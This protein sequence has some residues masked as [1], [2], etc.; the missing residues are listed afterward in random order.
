MIIGQ[1]RAGEDIAVALEV[2]DGDVAGL[3]VTASMLLI[4]SVQGA[5]IAM[6][7][8]PRAAT[9]TIPAG[10]NIVLPAAQSANIRAGR[11]I[12]DAKFQGAGS[13]DI[14]KQSANIMVSKSGFG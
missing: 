2:T 4:G 13:V 1:F 3:T 11:Y 7:V 12:I 5:P 9:S 6:D 14:T 8:L 10:W